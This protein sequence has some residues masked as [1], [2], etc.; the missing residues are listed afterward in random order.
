MLYKETLLFLLFVFLPLQ[1]GLGQCQGQSSISGSPKSF[2]FD[3]KTHSFEVNYCASKSDFSKRNVSIR[4]DPLNS[5][6]KKV[7]F[8]NLTGRSSFVNSL[9]PSGSLRKDLSLSKIYIDQIEFVGGAERFEFEVC[10]FKRDKG[11]LEKVACDGTFVVKRP[12]PKLEVSSGASKSFAPSPSH[13]GPDKSKITKLYSE[14]IK[15][16]YAG[17][18][19]N[20]RIEIQ[21]SK[22]FPASWRLE[23]Q[24]E[25]GKWQKIVENKPV[26]YTPRQTKEI[27]TVNYRITVPVYAES[28]SQTRILK[29]AVKK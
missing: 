24:I 11:S 25:S 28:Q 20:E 26:V 15:L 7:K 12:K 3:Q 21:L 6:S 4:I 8:N 17:F 22:N 16:D 9:E 19:N 10:L 14:D 18:H 29:F 5:P 2:T 27:L 1:N 23:V 13:S